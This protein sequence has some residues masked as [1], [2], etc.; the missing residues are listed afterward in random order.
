VLEFLS[1]LGFAVEVVRYGS[2]VL[3]EYKTMLQ[4]CSFSIF[5]TRAESQGLAMA[6]AWSCDV[7]TFVWRD[8]GDSK[9][10]YSSPLLSNATGQFFHEVAELRDLILSWSKY[11]CFEPRKWI[12]E[13][14]TEQIQAQ[15]LLEICGLGA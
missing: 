10:P 8:D 13:Q 14:L 11:R 12:L 1:S 2:Y 5:L 15:R 9:E 3:H 6:E 4:A 7:P